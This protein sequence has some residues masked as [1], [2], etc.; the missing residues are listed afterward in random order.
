MFKN[1]QAGKAFNRLQNDF[2]AASEEFEMC[3]RHYDAGEWSGPAWGRVYEETAQRHLKLVARAYHITTNDVWD[4]AQYL[5]HVEDQRRDEATIPWDAWTDDAGVSH[6]GRVCF[7]HHERGLNCSC[8][9]EAEQQR[10][11]AALARGEA[12]DD[13]IGP[14]WG[15]F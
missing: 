2:H 6:H 4:S 9:P 3:D 8:I 13:V 10:I 15:Q 14:E 7:E 12:A 5:E 11:K 1:K